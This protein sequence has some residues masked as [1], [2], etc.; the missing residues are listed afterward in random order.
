MNESGRF[1][2]DNLR[3]REQCQSLAMSLCVSVSLLAGTLF[4]FFFSKVYTASTAVGV[5]SGFSALAALG[6]TRVSMLSSHACVI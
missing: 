4:M 6:S 3:I 5:W 2:R 1:E